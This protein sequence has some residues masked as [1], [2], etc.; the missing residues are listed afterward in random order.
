MQHISDKVPETCSTTDNLVVFPVSLDPSDK[1]P[2]LQVVNRLK[3]TILPRQFSKSSK[4]ITLIPEQISPPVFCILCNRT[5]FHETVSERM[6]S[7]RQK[8]GVMHLGASRP[9][10]ADFSAGELSAIECSTGEED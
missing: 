10:E 9:T 1:D 5:R 2:S 4:W 6:R 3:G 7:I 8:T